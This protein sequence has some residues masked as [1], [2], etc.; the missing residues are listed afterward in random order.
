MLAI[1]ATVSMSNSAIRGVVLLG[2]AVGVLRA[3]DVNGDAVGH[4]VGVGHVI[5][6]GEDGVARAPDAGA[7]W[8]SV[9]ATSGAKVSVGSPPCPSLR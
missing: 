3:G 2:V 6:H 9:L 7:V 1:G 8:L 5:G 4:H